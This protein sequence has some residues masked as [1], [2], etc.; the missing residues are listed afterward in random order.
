LNQG[1]KTAKYPRQESND[2]AESPQ[3]PDASL[4]G[5]AEGGAVAN[6]AGPGGAIS[7]DPDAHLAEVVRRWP[8]LSVAAKENVVAIVRAFSGG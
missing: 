2:I 6:R 7:T 4:C 3:N 8:L 1:A 5:G